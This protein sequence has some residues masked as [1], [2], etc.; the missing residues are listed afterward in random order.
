MNSSKI[1]GRLPEHFPPNPRVDCLFMP[2]RRFQGLLAVTDA[3]LRQFHYLN[4]AGHRWLRLG[5]RDVLCFWRIADFCPKW[6]HDK[7]SAEIIPAL[8]RQGYWRGPVV[9][10]NDQA[11]TVALD[12]HIWRRGSAG[13]EAQGCLLL[14]QPQ[15]R[16]DLAQACRRTGNCHHKPGRSSITRE[17]ITDGWNRCDVVRADWSAVEDNHGLCTLLAFPIRQHEN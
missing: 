14:G 9:F 3:D 5:P 13:E 10:L 8:C 15:R 17:F 16:Q 1:N 7:I 4:R 12:M 6:F 11:A 2:D